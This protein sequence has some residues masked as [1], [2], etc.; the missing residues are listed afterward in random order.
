MKKFVSLHFKFL[1]LVGT[2]TTFAIVIFSIAGYKI[3][4]DNAREQSL[5]QARLIMK[6][7]ASVRHYTVN[8]IDPLLKLESFDRFI[9]QT[10]PAYAIDSYMK[11]LQESYPDYSYREATLN[12]TNLSHRAADWEADLISHFRN[13]EATQELVG[14][15][16]SS[17]GSFLYLAH[18]IKVSS[19]KCLTCHGSAIHAPKT[20]TDIYGNH[21]GFGWKLN[22]IV[23][24]QVVMVPTSATLKRTANVFLSYVAILVTVSVIVGVI[25]HI[26]LQRI[27]IKPISAVCD[28]ANKVSLGDIDVEELDITSNDE[29]GSL[30]RSFNRMH[31][32]VIT[33]INMLDEED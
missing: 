8:E 29:I 6:S 25:L 23:G 24:A 1:L 31:R 22:E 11:K 16:D 2:S 9:P 30:G 12:P 7:A 13:N 3:L 10:V 27:V 26:T 5:D 15:R 17:A 18:P 20:M 33:A 21:N 4:Y 14:D 32:S 28:K 19:Q